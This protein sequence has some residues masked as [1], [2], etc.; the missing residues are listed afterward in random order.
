MCLGLTLATGSAFT[1]GFARLLPGPYHVPLAFFLPQFLPVLL[2]AF[3][4]ARVRLTDWPKGR[5]AAP[6]AA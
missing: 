1:N 6:T 5:D 2:L 3:W 4:M